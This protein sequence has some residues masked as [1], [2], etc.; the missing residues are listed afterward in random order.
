MPLETTIRVNATV[1]NKS[2]KYNER[3]GDIFRTKERT[4]GILHLP[5]QIAD[6]KK[7]IDNFR[8]KMA[9]SAFFDD[10]YR[11]FMRKPALLRPV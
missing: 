7:H 9:A 8:V 10:L 11:F 6:F 5:E 4:A 3:E 1:T 2:C